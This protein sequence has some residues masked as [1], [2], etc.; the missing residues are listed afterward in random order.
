MII[1]AY[2]RKMSANIQR[3]VLW[4]DSLTK[5]YLTTYAEGLACVN[6]DNRLNYHVRRKDADTW[7][8][9]NKDI[10]GEH[11]LNSNR[12]NI[13]I[14]FY[15]VRKVSIDQEGY[16]SC[17]CGYVQRMLMPCVH[18]CAV[19][20]KKEYYVPSLFHIR[21]YKT[22]NYYYGQSFA[23]DIAPATLDAVEDSL[24]EV[25]NT[26][27]HEHSGYYKGVDIKTS[28]FYT[29][30]K[31]FD[32]PQSSYHDHIMKKMDD[33]MTYSVTQGPAI[34]GSFVPFT[35]LMT[36]DT[37]SNLINH[38]D[39]SI[40]G[41]SDDSSEINTTGNNHDNTVQGIV[42][43]SQVEVSLSQTRQNADDTPVLHNN[44]IT[45]YAYH[46][47]LTK[48]QDWFGSCKSVKQYERLMK[49]MTDCHFL[50]IAENTKTKTC[51][52]K[53][54]T[55]FGAYPTPQKNMKRKRFRHERY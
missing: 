29:E 28:L 14:Q 30:N 1:N 11:A 10:D 7:Y 33:I 6:F 25:R 55:L 24:D 9:L 16:M 37:E 52:N 46:D 23:K 19:V 40:N 39:E 53:D 31:S 34:K 21:W 47:V 44:A 12:E 41:F 35:E 20:G 51:T 38:H 15:R 50:N 18:V 17:S 2:N 42:S 5:D 4:S 32:P 8:V 36:V 22:F 27:Y 54:N 49:T 45:G 3:Q 48:F 43:S 26:Q 13:P